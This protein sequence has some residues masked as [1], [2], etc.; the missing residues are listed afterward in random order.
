MPVLTV[1]GHEMHY[2][3]HGTGEAVF[4]SGGW[5]TYCH[6]NTGHLPEGLVDRYR[7]VV[8]DH[9]GHRAVG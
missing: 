9:R 2:E 3:V 4:C 1:N 6:G 8:F 7:V 5:G